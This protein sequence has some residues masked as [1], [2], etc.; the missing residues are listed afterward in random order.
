MLF[1]KWYKF[2][3]KEKRERKSEQGKRRKERERKS[4]KGSTRGEEGRM[5]N[6]KDSNDNSVSFVSPRHSINDGGN[7]GCLMSLR[8]AAGGS[9]GERWFW[10]KNNFL[11]VQ[12]CAPPSFRVSR[13][14][15]RR[16][17]SSLSLSLSPLPVAV[18]LSR[19]IRSS[20]I[21]RVEFS[22]RRRSK[23]A[24]RLQS[25]D[26]QEQT[27]RENLEMAQIETRIEITFLIKIK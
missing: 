7:K 18:C 5:S 21:A 23:N 8:S 1:R 27:E 22:T 17:L 6:K 25:G 3:K 16:I 2:S 26:N 15:S 11:R 24:C 19:A 20:L 10:K 13:S 12:N 9:T 14:I 4:K